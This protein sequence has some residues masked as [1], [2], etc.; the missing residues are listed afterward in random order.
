MVYDWSENVFLENAQP[1]SIVRHAGT[2]PLLMMA[3]KQRAQPLLGQLMTELLDRAPEHVRQFIALA[4]QEEEQREQSLEI[5]EKAW[6]LVE[7]SYSIFVNE[8]LPSLDEFE[9]LLSVAAQWSTPELTLDLPPP[10]KP[11]P[12]PEISVAVKLRNRDQFL[13]GCKEIY[14]VFD[15]VVDLVREVQPDSLPAG[16]SVPRPQQEELA[17][18]TRFY[19]EGFPQGAFEGFEPQVIVSNDTVVLG[20]SSRHVL[21]VIQVRPLATRPAWFAPEMPVA[22]M[23]LINIAGMVDAVSPWL[24]FGFQILVGD[25]DTPVMMNEGPVPTGGE[26][27]QIWDCLTSLGKVAAT[28][29]IDNEG[30]TISRWV[31]VGQ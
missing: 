27:V 3:V 12:L 20:Y 7:E 14:G 4:E 21:D 23:S 22:S 29:V 8:I 26:I 15:K 2:K 17:G 5:L 30:V 31:W 11:L 18:A 1:M 28:T 13:T 9:G 6:P 10:A 24:E 25:L 19:Y 16:Y